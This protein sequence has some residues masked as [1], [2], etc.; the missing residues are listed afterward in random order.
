MNEFD[1]IMKSFSQDEN[2][3][4]WELDNICGYILIASK[5][6][7]LYCH[8]YYYTTPIYQLFSP[9]GKRLAANPSYDTVKAM[10]NRLTS[11]KR[12]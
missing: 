10:L 2:T 3:E 4:V 8:N 5:K 6:K 9:D 1:L 7:Y 11:N 12:R